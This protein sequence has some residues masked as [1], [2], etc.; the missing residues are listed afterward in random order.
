MVW[1]GGAKDRLRLQ[2]AC[3]VPEGASSLEAW[4]V[5]FDAEGIAGV[6]GGLCGHLSAASLSMTCTPTE[7]L[8]P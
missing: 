3:A 8:V 6:F 7:K 2:G 5:F 1:R 4:W